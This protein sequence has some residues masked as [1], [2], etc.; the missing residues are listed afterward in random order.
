MEIICRDRAGAYAEGAHRGAPD[1]VQVADRLHL[2][3]GLG[4]AVETCVAAHRDCLRNPSVSGPLAEATRLAT[5]RPQDDP[6]PLGR[7]TERKKAARA[8]VHELLSQGHSRRA[9]ARHLGWGLNTVL[10][11]ANAAHWQD[12]FRENRPR[13]SRLDA[14]KPYLE[15]RFAEGCTSGTQLHGPTKPSASRTDATSWASRLTPY[16]STRRSRSHAASSSR[17][18]A[19][20]RQ[21]PSCWIS[22]ACERACAV[23]L[24]VLL[25]D[26]G[27]CDSQLLGQVLGPATST[28]TCRGSGGRRHGQSWSDS[29]SWT[30]RTGLSAPMRIPDNALGCSRLLI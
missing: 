24:P 18:S 22:P 8:L 14:Y 7:R 21:P 29:S 3:Q 11:Y 25:Q 28:G 17:T 5:G 30:T 9:I 26:R 4:R 27:G 10:R 6:A 15:R 12:T 2:W 23:V 20:S 13:P 1:A 19:K 16:S